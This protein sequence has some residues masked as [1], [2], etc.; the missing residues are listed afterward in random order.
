[1][2]VVN[3]FG[4]AKLDS[5]T[6]VHSVLIIW[7]FLADIKIQLASDKLSVKVGQ[8][9]KSSFSGLRQPFLDMILWWFDGFHREPWHYQY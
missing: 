8:L 7:I 5:D 2:S 3:A 6:N 4:R 9:T 1:M